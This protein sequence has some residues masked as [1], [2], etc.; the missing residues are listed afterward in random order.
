MRVFVTKWLLHGMARLPL[1]LAQACGALMG[2]SLSWTNNRQRRICQ[3]NIQACFPELDRQQQDALVTATLID[4]GRTSTETGCLWFGAPARV[5]AMF[6]EVHGEEHLR[7][8]I[9]ARHGVILASPHLGNWEAVNLYCSARYPLTS[10]YRPPRMVEL[11]E[12]VRS[13]RQRFGAQLVPTNPQ[14]VKALYKALADNQ[15]VM[16]LPD[17]DPRRG[18][19]EFAPFF[20]IEANTMTLLSRLA[21]KSGATVVCAYAE[22][23][24]AGRGFA[25]RFEAVDQAVADADLRTSLTA[26][27]QALERAIRTIPSQ[28]QWCY[29][30]FLTRPEG[31]ASFY[32]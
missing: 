28:Y 3:R 13:A 32:D 5:E 15:L 10:L 20:G 24:P 18:A 27:N 19:G 14:G 9:D 31:E 22:R 16:I 21:R 6:T 2:L 26:L 29:K 4:T 17:Q 23:L 12:M 1:R 30:R 7:A 8:A 11:D 25:L